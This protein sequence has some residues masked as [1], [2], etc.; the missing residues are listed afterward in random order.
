MKKKKKKRKRLETDYHKTTHELENTWHSHAAK[1]F[2]VRE[3]LSEQFFFFF[4]Y[5]TV[6][7]FSFVHVLQLRVLSHIA[8]PHLD[9]GQVRSLEKEKEM[10]VVN[11][12]YLLLL[13]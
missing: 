2:T 8:N 9:I 6:S 12:L 10:S 11:I 4:L 5:T 3:L 13:A 7:L 1:I